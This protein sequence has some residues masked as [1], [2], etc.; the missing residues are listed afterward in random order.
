M[1]GFNKENLSS[2]VKILKIL[3]LILSPFTAG[4][5]IYLIENYD[6]YLFF[7]GLAL[8]FITF[9]ALGVMI[10]S[11]SRKNYN[12]IL[13][14]M[15]LVVFSFWLKNKHWPLSGAFMTLGFG[16]LGSVSFFM[17]LG[18]LRRFK[19]NAFLKYIGFSSSLVLSVVSIGLLFKNMH[20]PFAGYMISAGMITFITF[21]FAF[22]FLLP[23]ANFV[24]WNKSERIVFFRAI[25]FPM[26]FIYGLCVLMF[27]FPSVWTM[28]IQ[29]PSYPFAMRP[30]ELLHTISIH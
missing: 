16:G 1:D 20:W 13:F 4:S 12:W 2:R 24:N 3:V 14:F 15:V 21:L 28:L 22:V 25:V 18:F 8:L 6:N 7:T 10:A 5:A 29:T 26:I 11:Y 19:I 17:S 30:V 23:N 27:V 9:I